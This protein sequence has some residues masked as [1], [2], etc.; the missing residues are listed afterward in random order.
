VRRLLRLALLTLAEVARSWLWTLRWLRTWRRADWVAWRRMTLPQ[1]AIARAFAVP[2]STLGDTARTYSSAE[3][4]QRAFVERQ[5]QVFREAAEQELA[6]LEQ[7]RRT[8]GT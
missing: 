4:E 3:R 7:R 2:P 5:Q 8:E 6:R 1:R